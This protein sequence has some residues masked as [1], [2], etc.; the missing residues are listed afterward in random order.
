MKLKD[1]MRSQVL[2]KVKKIV[3]KI[4]TG[5]LTTDNGYLDKEQIKGLAGQV[6][7][8][9]KMGYRV[10]V[11]S[12][13]AIGS[14]MGELGIGKRPGTLPELQAVAAIGQSKLISMYDACFKL[15]GY[16]AAQILLTREDFE[17]RQRYLNTCNTIHTLFQLNAI[18]VVNENDTISVE[19]I[20]F[21]DNDALSAM[22]T[23]L[24]NAE[25]LI[26]LSSVDGLYDRCPTAKNKATVIPVVEDVSDEIK[27][28]A[29]NS[30]TQRGVGG[31]QTKLEAV[32]VV[33]KAGEAVIIA[34]GRT[35]KVLKR[36]V[37]GEDMGTLFLPKKE[38][39]ANRKRWIGFTIKPKGKIYVDDG[40][41]SALT[42]K[43]KSLLAT[44]IV[45][46]EGAFDKGDTIS[47]C[48][49]G[50]GAIFA[51]GLTNYSSKEIEKIKG[52]STSSITKIL[53]YKLY[54]EI[55]HRDNMVIL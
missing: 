31:M 40:A 55:I 19:E 51:K 32:S 14:G 37:Q 52:C 22:V 5:V 54:D 4:G 23:N 16:H 6:V 34:N 12:S 13:G 35:D 38:K 53:G 7:E 24:L 48:K 18:P 25:L 39:L 46:V 11:V 28:L 29:F 50:D 17:D 44:G 27:Q 33:V 9:K 43:G 45:S 41:M 15:H 1:E 42:E 20:K 47:I 21:G 30:K 10:V 36:I 26:I 2:S 8:L 49:K 3:I